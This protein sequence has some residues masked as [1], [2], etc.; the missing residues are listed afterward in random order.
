[1]QQH[2]ITAHGAPKLLRLQNM[3]TL[4]DGLSLAASESSLPSSQEALTSILQDSEFTSPKPAL[5]SSSG[6]HSPSPEPSYPA[7][8]RHEPMT[9]GTSCNISLRSSSPEMP[10]T[11]LRWP[12]SPKPPFGGPAMTLTAS[13]GVSLPPDSPD[14]GQMPTRGRQAVSCINA[15]DEEDKIQLFLS[16]QKHH[17]R[18]HSAGLN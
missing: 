4:P 15:S 11:P 6:P 17:E 7:F 18:E 13:L 9:A 14:P 10:G 8:T 16:P 1:M 12:E 5:A 2:L 3:N